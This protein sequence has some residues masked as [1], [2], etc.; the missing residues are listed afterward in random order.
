MNFLRE[1]I[2]VVFMGTPEFA[3][4]SLEKLVESKYNV[5]GVFTNPDKPAGRGMKLKPSA[6]KE[7]AIKNNL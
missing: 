6:V 5:V 2:K 1:D 4:C 7:Y 3:K